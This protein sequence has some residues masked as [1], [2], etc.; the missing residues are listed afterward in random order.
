MEVNRMEQATVLDPAF[1]V[2]D[3]LAAKSGVFESIDKIWFKKLASAVIDADRCVKCGACIAAC[4][5]NSIGIAE[6]YKPTLVKMCTG[7]SFCWDI[8]PRGGLRYERLWKILSGD[9]GAKGIGVVRDAYTARALKPSPCAQDGG[10]VTAIVEALLKAGE[11]DGAILARRAGSPFRGEAYIAK[12]VEEVRASAGSVY[13]QT[14]NLSKLLDVSSYGQRSDVRL[15]LVGVPCQI[16][17][18]RFLQ[19]FGW[20]YRK[21]NA[22]SVKYTIALMCTRNFHSG[23]LIYALKNV[24][25]N[26][27]RIKKMDVKNN[28][29]QLYDENGE[30][31]FK[32]DVRPFRDAALKGCDECADFSGRLA[33]ISVGSV[34]SLRGYSSIL[35]RTPQGERAWN[36]AKD[37]LE[38]RRLD[39]MEGIF[40]VEQRKLKKVL[41]ELKRGFDPDA[42]LWICYKDH[43]T[44]YA[45]TE[46]TPVKPMSYRIHHYDIT[47]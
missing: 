20:K 38:Y 47:C 23:R 43:L 33:D 4:P 12:T 21:V 46:R 5:S 25:V 15:A 36:I 40:R 37:S 44:S 19:R 3:Q 22:C 17:G 26:L 14:L 1:D 39:D 45:G 8:C 6:D 34:G 31:I 9:E 35:I 2:R 18:L 29:V 24:G 32:S 27:S 7:C 11:V 41:K 16:A 42:P 28:V 13:D 10:V 30:T